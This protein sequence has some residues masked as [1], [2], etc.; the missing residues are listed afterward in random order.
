MTYGRGE[1]VV[2]ATGMNTEV[3]NIAKMLNE[4]DETDTPLKQ[5]LNQLGKT[6]TYMILA[7]CVVV[8]IIGVIRNPQHEPMN[9]LLID[10]FLTAVSLAVASIP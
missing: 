7:I 2:V 1:G 10:M 8:F 3:G 4:A 6:L 5:N 9:A